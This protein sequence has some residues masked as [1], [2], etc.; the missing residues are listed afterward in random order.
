MK[1]KIVKQGAATLMVSLPSK[2]CK[3]FSIEKGDEVNMEATDS[4]LII[5]PKEIK[6]KS[7]TEVTLTGLTESFIKTLIVNTYRMGYEKIKV[8]FSSDFQFRV[9]QEVIKTGLVGFDVIKKEKK[10]SII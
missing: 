7:E 10:Y 5:S 2:W 4:N 1:R 9:L 3:Q 8:N 6:I